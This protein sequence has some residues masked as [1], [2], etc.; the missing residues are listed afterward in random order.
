VVCAMCF[1]LFANRWTVALQTPLSMGF[2]RQ[3]YWSGWPFPSPRDVPHPGVNPQVSCVSYI[4]SRFFTI[5]GKPCGAVGYYQFMGF[6]FS[7]L[8]LN[9]GTRIAKG[10]GTSE[11]EDWM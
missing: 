6:G 9:L 8:F 7:G 5:P 1:R 3:E 4:A 2:S 10:R 11:A